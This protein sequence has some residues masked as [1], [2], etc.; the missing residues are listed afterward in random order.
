LPIDATIK[1]LIFISNPTTTALK[2][3]P[4]QRP[5]KTATRTPIQT[6]LSSNKTVKET[7]YKRLQTL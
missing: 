4:L 5:S 3:L 7:T 2:S 6:L 1:A